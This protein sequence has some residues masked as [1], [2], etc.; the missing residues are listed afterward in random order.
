MSR[1][2]TREEQAQLDA[3]SWTDIHRAMA[4]YGHDSRQEPIRRA[5]VSFI[6]KRSVFQ[7]APYTADEGHAVQ[8]AREIPLDLKS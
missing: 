6:L 3:L 2:I 5:L 4:S 1:D 7:L 8:F